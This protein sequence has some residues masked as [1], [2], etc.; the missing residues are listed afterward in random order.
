MG[1]VKR[2]VLLFQICSQFILPAA[3]Q[4]FCH[5]KGKSVNCPLHDSHNYKTS[6]TV[7][8]FSRMKNPPLFG[9][10]IVK[11]ITV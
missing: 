2:E 11:V 6:A 4:F 9:S 8:V 10:S 3:L 7:Q 5:E 1:C